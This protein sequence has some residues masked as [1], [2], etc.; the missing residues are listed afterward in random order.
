MRKLSIVA[1]SITV[2]LLIM[3]ADNPA[4]AQERGIVEGGLSGLGAA[5]DYIAVGVGGIY[6]GAVVRAAGPLAVY[7]NLNYYPD[8]DDGNGQVGAEVRLGSPYWIVRPSIRAGLLQGSA[9]FLSGGFGLTMGRR[10]GGRFV[11][12]G[13]YRSGISFAVVHLGG[14]VGF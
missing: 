5:N 13:T 1:M 6:A 3:S 11:V 12:D 8:V 4:A 2:L 7:A 14:Y 9:S 10:F